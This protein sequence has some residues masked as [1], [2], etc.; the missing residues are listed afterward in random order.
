MRIDTQAMISTTAF[1]GRRALEIVDRYGPELVDACIEEMIKR[2]E[3]AM[4]A[5]IAAIPDGVY[6]GEAATDDDGTVL[7]EPVWIRVE[8]VV[9]GDQMT[10][11]FT[12]SDAQRP[13]FV[14]RV[15]AATYGTAFGSVLMMMDASLA[16]YHNEGSLRPLT[17]VAPE[18]TVTNARYPA[19]VGG[20]PV[21]V[22]GQI[23]DAIM[24]A[25]S[26]ACPD[27]AQA[28]WA[29]HR[30]DYTFAND[31]R[32]GEP[33]VRTTFDYDG[34]AGAVAGYD[35]ATGPV[36]HGVVLRGNVEEAELRFPWKMLNLEIVP[37][38]M[39]AGCWRAGAGIDWRAVN[40]GSEGRMATGSSDGD[41]MV[42]KGVL[43][44]YDSPKSR[45]FIQRGDERIRVK[46]HRMQELRPGDVLIKLSSG[47]GGVGDPR[48]RDPLAVRRDVRDG[49]VS[50]EA[51]EKIYAVALDAESLD[52]DDQRTA[53]LRSR[54]A[55]EVEVV[56]DGETLT[57]GLRELG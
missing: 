20:S 23:T 22:G 50:L 12:K 30:G 4:R 9:R 35:G 11:D 27:R 39:G 29:K 24:E 37:D 47:G 53:E 42:P 55:T 31:P 45:T 16:G 14:N 1:G 26:K 38:L 6:Y 3:R 25:L 46:P 18:G 43:G 10:I 41:E 40:W 32:T 44:G 52:I 2:T 49:F 36:V 33:Y 13:G 17:I 5:H 15:L 56:I 51:A 28:A 34:S 8:I 57:V 7:D 21:A 19:T 54:R 48:E